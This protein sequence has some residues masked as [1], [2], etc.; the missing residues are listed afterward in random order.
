M[1]LHNETNFSYMLL[2]R[3]QHGLFFPEFACLFRPLIPESLAT[4]L[5]GGRTP[6]E[7]LS[8]AQNL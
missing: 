6:D 5:K 8:A 2:C 3:L 7:K 1:L 4:W